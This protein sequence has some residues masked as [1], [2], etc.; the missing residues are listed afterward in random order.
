M[1]DWVTEGQGLAGIIGAIT[2]LLGVFFGYKI[3]K[4][5]S[6]QT[7]NDSLWEKSESHWASIL[8][9][10]EKF[11]KEIK[12]DLQKVKQERDSVFSRLR[13]LEISFTELMKENLEMK[14]REIVLEHQIDD[15]KRENEELKIL[16]NDSEKYRCKMA[17]NCENNQRVDGPCS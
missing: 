13:E 7:L 4:K 5:K 15:L 1:P 12:E 17:D 16:V 2:G 6:D 8:E 3:K 10:N 14:K 9:D 11:R